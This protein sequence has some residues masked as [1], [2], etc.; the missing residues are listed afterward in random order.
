MWPGIVKDGRSKCVLPFP[1][2]ICKVY[3][4][5]DLMDFGGL[6]IFIIFLRGLPLVGVFLFFSFAGYISFFHLQDSMHG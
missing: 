3:L 5:K 2:L 1:Y 4:E 6:V